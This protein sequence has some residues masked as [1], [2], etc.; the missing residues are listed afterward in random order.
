MLS[1]E[2]F[3]SVK[4]YGS[5]SRNNIHNKESDFRVDMDM[6]SVQQLRKVIKEDKDGTMK[7]IAIFEERYRKDGSVSKGK[8][9]KV[10]DDSTQSI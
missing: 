3:G 1:R 9:I 6:V 5:S 4:V 10:Q 7:S 8:Q 2:A